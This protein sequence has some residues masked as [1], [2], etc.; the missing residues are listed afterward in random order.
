VSEQD[1]ETIRFRREVIEQVEQLATQQGISVD[2]WIRAA[3]QAEIDRREY[4]P[5]RES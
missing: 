5:Q 2:A 3:I 4:R 1:H